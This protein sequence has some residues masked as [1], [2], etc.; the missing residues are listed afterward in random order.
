MAQDWF[1]QFIERSEQ[2]SVQAEHSLLMALTWGEMAKNVL[3]ITSVN[4][5]CEQ[6]NVSLHDWTSGILE[7]HA[8]GWIA[9]VEL[10]PLR[11]RLVLAAPR[12]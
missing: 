3:V 2:V 5:R 11:T 9:S 7:L 6:Y 10:D 1:V 8:S 12:P 4:S